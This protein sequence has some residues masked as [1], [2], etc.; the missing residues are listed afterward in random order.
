MSAAHDLAEAILKGHAE[1]VDA[2]LAAPADFAGARVE[3]VHVPPIE[4][5][6]IKDGP[7]MAGLWRQ[8][9]SMLRQRMPDFAIT[10]LVVEA[11]SPT[12]VVVQAVTSGTPA[13]GGQVSRPFRIDYSLNE[14]RIVKA[15]A[16]YPEDSE[17]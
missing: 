5:D 1:S 17:A 13:E 16:S 11:T 7:E 14:G 9:G 12:A 3:I 2:G 15:V 6:G 8:E 10:D 4:S